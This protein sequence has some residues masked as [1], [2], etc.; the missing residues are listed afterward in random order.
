MIRKPGI[1]LLTI[2]LLAPCAHSETFRELKLQPKAKSAHS[3]ADRVN[4]K[5]M[6]LTRSLDLSPEQVAKIKSILLKA[7]QDT[8]RI[9]TEAKKAVIDALVKANDEI[10]LTLDKGQKKS[11]DRLR[12]K[13]ERP[14]KIQE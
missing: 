8:S 5:L 12:K 11:F 1:V 6:D 14:P 3:L 10:A 13:Y 7:Q 2:F 4:Q 9:L